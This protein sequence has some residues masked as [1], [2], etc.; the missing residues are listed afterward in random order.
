MRLISF[1]LTEPQFV[2]GEKDVTRRLGWLHAK[3]GDHLMGIRKG[4]GLKPGEKI[5]RLGEIIVKTKRRERLD[6]IT[7]DDVRREGFGDLTGRG[8]VEMFCRH[9]KC[10]P[11]RVVTRI[12]FVGACCGH[13]PHGGPCQFPVDKDRY[14]VAGE[15][16]CG[17]EDW[18][19]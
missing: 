14:G 15:A 16:P 18:P 10:K 9:M 8:F 1:A 17:C 11:D 6:E 4:M 19:S 3:P 12:E 7:E 13:P 5:V 2:R